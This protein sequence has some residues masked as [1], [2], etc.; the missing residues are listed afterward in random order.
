MNCQSL[1]RQDSAFLWELEPNHCSYQWL[2][3]VFETCILRVE[4]ALKVT[5]NGFFRTYV[6]P[7]A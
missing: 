1:Y 7:I 5:V 3:L 4:E 2:A 6:W